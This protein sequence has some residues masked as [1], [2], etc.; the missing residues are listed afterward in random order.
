[1]RIFTDEGDYRQFVHLL[2]D[3]CGVFAIECWSYCIMPNHYHAALRPTRPNISEAMRHL[4]SRYA[5]WWN[6]RHGTVGHA[7]QGRFKDQIVQHEAY[8]FALLRYIARN[9]VRAGL[10]DCPSQWRW[11]SYGAF[12]GTESAAP[13]LSVSTVLA[14]FGEADP[15]QLQERYV[16]HVLLDPSDDK[17]FED[18]IH[19]QERILGDAAFK[20]LVTLQ[21]DTER[22]EVDQGREHAAETAGSSAEGAVAR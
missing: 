12:A 8:L 9:P 16:R 10:V 20:Q 1:M 7:F 22:L 11:S 18:R 4:N 21:A 13:F 14:A 2:G 5:Q 17:A 6:G 19:S 3:I 15:S